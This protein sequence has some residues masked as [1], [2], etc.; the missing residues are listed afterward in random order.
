MVWCAHSVDQAHGWG[1]QVLGPEHQD[2]LSNLSG[3]STALFE[4]GRQDEAIS[5]AQLALKSLSRVC[6]SSPTSGG[7]ANQKLNY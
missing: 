4:L 3:M 6:S 2:T 1:T 5:V 7:D